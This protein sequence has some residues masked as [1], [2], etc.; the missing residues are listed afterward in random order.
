MRSLWDESVRLNRSA[1][2]AWFWNAFSHMS[3]PGTN[4]SLQRIATVALLES[5]PVLA[6]GAEDLSAPTIQARL[7]PGK[8]MNLL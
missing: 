3:F 4:Q 1:P 5:N 6:A 2:L 8:R 7:K